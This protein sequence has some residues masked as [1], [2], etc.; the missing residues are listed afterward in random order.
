MG[1]VEFYREKEFKKTEVGE[2][3]KEWE[4]RR[5]GEVVEK[6]QYGYTGSA[7]YQGNFKFLRITDINKEGLY[8]NWNKVPFVFIDEKEAQ[9]YRLS[10]GDVVIARIGATTGA[11]AIVLDDVKAIFASYLIRIKPYKNLNPLFLFYFTNSSTYWRQINQQKEGALKKGI[12]TK[13]LANISIPLPPLSEQKAIAKVLKD[14]D[15]LLEVIEEKIKTLQRIKKGL[16]EVY[17]TKG[18]FKHKEFKDTEIG[19]IPK[20]WEVRRLGDKCIIE[21]GGTPNRNV[22]D[23]WNGNIN[24]LT[25]EVCK[26]S[27]IYEHIVKEKITEAGLNKS[28]ARLFPP[29][30]V[31]IALV[32]ATLGKVAYLTF[33]SCTNQNVAGIYR[34]KGIFPK[35]LFYFLKLLNLKGFFVVKGYKVMTLKFIKNLLI[36][37]PPLEEQKAIAE[38]LK[39]IDDQIENL[40]SQKE[41]LQKIK[42]KFMDLLLTGKV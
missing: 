36:P 32:G 22:K 12:N 19:R 41:S 20:E 38:R 8:I 23:F 7:I 37:L 24:W 34:C 13:I 30:T 42:K 15:D 3:P 18:V 17:F 9:D 31:L 35:Y 6:I 28:N 29:D 1:K 40:K 5:L 26:N 14:F 10:I 4:V 39:T 27:F 25:S 33:E 16:M 2:I 21:S 11:S